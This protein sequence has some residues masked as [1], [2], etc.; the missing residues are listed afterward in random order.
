MRAAPNLGSA[1]VAAF[2]AV[3]PALAEQSGALLV[4]FLLEGVAGRPELN[5]ADGIHPSAEGHRHITETLWPVLAPVL[6][7]ARGRD[8][9]ASARVVAE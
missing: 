4:P 2:E 1:Y 6:A 5:Q 8:P 9:T 7:A 3:Y